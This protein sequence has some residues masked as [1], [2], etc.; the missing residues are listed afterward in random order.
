MVSSLPGV[1]FFCH[2]HQRV[3]LGSQHRARLPDQLFQSFFDVVCC[4][5]LHMTVYEMTLATR[6]V[7]HFQE[8]PADVER[9]EHLQEVQPTLGLLIKLPTVVCPVQLIVQP[10]PKV[11]I[12]LHDLHLLTLDGNWSWFEFG[13]PKVYDHLL[14]L[15][16]VELI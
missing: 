9:P 4:S 12:G 5:P 11:Y 3:Q 6:V 1:L 15:G 10:Q 16:V 7:K 13:F 2:C 8:F 14:G